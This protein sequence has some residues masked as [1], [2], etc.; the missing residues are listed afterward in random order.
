VGLASKANCAKK[1]DTN[2]RP[3]ALFNTFGLS[4]SVVDKSIS[5]LGWPPLMEVNVFL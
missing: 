5:T 4:A 3:L 1:G 2:R